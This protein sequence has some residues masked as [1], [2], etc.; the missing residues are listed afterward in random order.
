MRLQT[1]SAED[2]LVKKLWWTKLG[3][4]ERQMNDAAGIVKVQAGS[5]DVEYV[6]RWVAVLEL[7]EQWQEVLRRVG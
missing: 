4:S 7:D 2:I 3:P 6:E 1:A 5:L